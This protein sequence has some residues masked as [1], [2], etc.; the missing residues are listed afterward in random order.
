MGWWLEAKDAYDQFNTLLQTRP[1]LK[2]WQ[3]TADRFYAEMLIF[4]KH[5]ATDLLTK[6]WRE[7]QKDANKNQ[8][9]IREIYRLRGES[10][11]LQGQFSTAAGFFLD[12]ITLGHKSGIPVSGLLGRLAYVRVC[13]ELYDEAQ[14]L[15]A[16]AFAGDEAGRLHDLYNSAAEVYL[17]LGDTEQAR[18]YATMA[19]ESA[20][21]DGLP[22]VWWWR[23]ERARQVLDQVNA[24]VPDLPPFDEERIEKVPYEAEIYAF[25]HE[26][27]QGVKP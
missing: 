11:L 25:I 22:F 6:I 2:K 12:T 3:A 23:M 8:V 27:Q 17:T 4:Q 21:A 7:A 18:Q 14:Q 9:H 13:E 15:L 26:L 19:Y 20:W 5:D 16:E 1:A 24:P 10:A